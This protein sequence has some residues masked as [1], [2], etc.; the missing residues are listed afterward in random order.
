MENVS[1]SLSSLS[2]YLGALVWDRDAIEL[3][4]RTG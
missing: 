2:G 1:Q 4:A 3:A